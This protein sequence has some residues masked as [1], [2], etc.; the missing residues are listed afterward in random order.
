MKFGQ[1]K[2]NSDYY[3]SENQLKFFRR[4]KK[5]DND[6]FIL[7]I[8]LTLAILLIVSFSIYI[9]TLP[10]RTKKGEDLKN[11]PQDYLKNIPKEI[12]NKIDWKNLKHYWYPICL[13][14]EVTKDKPLGTKIFDMPIVLYR[15]KN[16]KVVCSEDRCPHRVAQISGGR[17]I[18]GEI[19]CPYHGKVYKVL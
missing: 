7:S 5:S 4:F 14:E 15:D 16:G 2:N 13:S 8:I 6:F 17:M 18:N 11:L 19:E 10:P 9:S 1:R 3:R 12:L